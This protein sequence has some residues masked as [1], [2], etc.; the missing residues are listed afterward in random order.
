ML[1]PDYG[2]HKNPLARVL[3]YIHAK[4]TSS[5]L[6]DSVNP[7]QELKEVGSLCYYL[8]IVTK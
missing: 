2:Y 8:C 6:G 4:P 7:P 1:W 5:L 3:A